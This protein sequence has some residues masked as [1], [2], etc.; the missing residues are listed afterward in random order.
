MTEQST[1][2]GVSDAKE[3]Q[4]DSTENS[5]IDDAFGMEIRRRLKLESF[6]A[7]GLG[8]NKEKIGRVDTFWKVVWPKLEESGWRKENGTGHNLGGIKFFFPPFLKNFI[9]AKR[10]DHYERI[11]DVLDRILGRH[12]Q[13]ETAAADA[14]EAEMKKVLKLLSKPEGRK[15]GPVKDDTTLTWSKGQAP[16]KQML[17]LSWKEGGRNFPK[18]SSRIGREYQVE[19]TPNAGTWKAPE[20]DDERQYEQVW[21][22]V[23]AV[24]K[25]IDLADIVKDVP[26]NKKEKALIWLGAH[27]YEIAGFEEAV[28]NMECDNG[29]DWNP[30]M[31]RRF[32][33]EIFRSRKDMDAVHGAMEIEMKTCLAYY[34]GTFRMSN[35]YR[36]L[37]T[38][39]E[40]ERQEGYSAT[41]HGKDA[42]AICGDGGSLLICDGCEGEYH[43][44]CVQPS[45]AEIPEGHWECD[46]C[47]NE[48]FL[49]AREHLIRNSELFEKAQSESKDTTDPMDSEFIAYRPTDFALQSVS[50]MA[51][52]VSEALRNFSPPGTVAS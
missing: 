1:G 9:V 21:D 22:P 6:V 49:A 2:L 52:R 12:T 25:G 37:K 29:S 36:L 35:D 41:E 17:D 42:C 47:V 15:R 23:L 40:E 13:D 5:S 28:K 48:K 34:L 27:E 51:M 46:D 31:R 8:K 30:D 43:M 10:E 44:D 19:D 39:C 50:K 3:D 38:V 24:A 20:N 7:S 11:R 4:Q 32:R 14:Y 45:L 33:D 18:K 26:S 16:K